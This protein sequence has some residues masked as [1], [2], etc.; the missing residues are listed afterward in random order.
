V[1]SFDSLKGRR[2]FTLVMRKGR[3]ASTRVLTVY[4]FVPRGRAR[5]S[6]PKLG[7]VITK[8]VGNAVVRNLLRRRCKALFAGFASANDP[9]WFLVQ[10][11]PEAARVPF[12]ALREQLM[13]AL[14]AAAA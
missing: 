5:T 13:P 8:K 9:R 14:K 7:V 2:E 10:C 12:A 1:P 3:I 11:K 6:V 4:A